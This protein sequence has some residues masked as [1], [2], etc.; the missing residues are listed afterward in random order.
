MHFSPHVT[1]QTFAPELVWERMGVEV[2]NYINLKIV[3]F[4]RTIFHL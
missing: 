1:T 3:S 4:C 2:Q